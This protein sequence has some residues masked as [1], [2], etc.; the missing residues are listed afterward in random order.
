[1]M[2]SYDYGLADFEYIAAGAAVL[3]SGGGGSYLDA[4]SILNELGQSGWTGSV[5]VRP[6]DGSSNCCVVAMMGSPDAGDALTLV[7]IQNSVANTLFLLQSTTGY[8]TSCVIPVEIGAIN[9][10]VPLL[11]AV[12]CADTLWVI[13]GD[14]AGR[15]VPE[16]PQTTFVGAANL[17]VSPCALATD[18]ADYS[19]AESALL[20]APTAA[21]METLAGGVVGGFGG[22]SGIALW[23]S[24]ASN[25]YGLTGNYIP[26]TLA[27]AWGL[28]QFLLQGSTPQSSASVAAQIALLTGRTASVA[29]SNFYITS[30][31][32][33]TTSASLDAGVIRLDNTQDPAQS[34]Q[35]CSIYNMNENLIM[36]SSQSTAPMII[37]PDSICYYSESTGLGFSNA[38][39]D[40][41]VY[42]DSATGKSTGKM[43]SIIQ[44]STAPQLYATPGVLDSFASLL[45]DIGYAGAMPSN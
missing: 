4:L 8:T 15:A 34:T 23:P 16:L 33:T 40:L 2:T 7:D 29:V 31:T 20:S 39:D 5:T 11:G 10:L 25:N 17:P 43:V 45:R 13:D 14:G 35:T 9:S 6:Y 36:Y 3:A 22:F 1:M 38:S 26:G 37:A 28:G 44:V 18:V 30:V 24:N 42:F 19:T 32:Q 12:A 41:A 21:Q 27:Q